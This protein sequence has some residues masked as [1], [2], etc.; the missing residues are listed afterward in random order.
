L[1]KRSWSEAGAG[2]GVVGA[3]KSIVGEAKIYWS[4]SEAGPAEFSGISSMN[5]IVGGDVLRFLLST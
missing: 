3:T 4:W 1:E 5:S 2:T